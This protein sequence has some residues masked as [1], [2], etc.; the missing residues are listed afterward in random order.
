M[1]VVSIADFHTCFSSE[2]G[3]KQSRF[4]DPV[5]AKDHP[6]L[7]WYLATMRA[8][9]SRA[10]RGALLTIQVCDN[11]APYHLVAVDL[12]EGWFFVI[13]TVIFPRLRHAVASSMRAQ[14]IH[15]CV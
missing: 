3:P 2:M 11:F 13:A 15:L 10:M 7:K 5:A 4:S 9:D 14:T 1:L 6:W 12:E 8:V